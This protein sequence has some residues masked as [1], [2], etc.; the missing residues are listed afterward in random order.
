MRPEIILFTSIAFG[1]LSLLRAYLVERNSKRREN[2]L[3]T[4]IRKLYYGDK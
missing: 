2:Q 1:V 4:N 3:P